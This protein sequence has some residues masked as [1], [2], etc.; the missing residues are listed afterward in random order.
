[1]KELRVRL[2]LRVS[3]NQQLEAD[4][5]LKIQRAID[6]E[7]V[8]SHWDEGWRLDGKEYFEGSNSGYHNGVLDRNILTEIRSDA[9]NNEFDILVVYKDDRVGRRMWEM[10]MFIMQL[11]SLGVDVYTVKD[12]CISPELDDIMGQMMLALRYGNAQKS[13]ADTGMRVRDTAEKLVKTGKFIGGKAGYGYKLILSGELSKHGRAL[14]KRQIVPEQA[15]AINY[16]FLLADIKEYGSTKIAKVLNQ[17]EYY[18]SLAPNDEWKSGTITSI[19]TNPLYAGYVSYNR[20]KKMNGKFR[21][22]S[23][24][25]WSIAEQPNE[26]IRIVDEERWER[27]QVKR[28]LRGAKY[29]KSLANKNVTVVNRNYGSLALID[30]AYCGYCGS[31]LTNG[32]KYNYWTIKGTGERRASKTPIYK[33]QNA[34]QGVVHDK[35]YQ[36]RADKVEAIIFWAISIYLD[37][38]L[39]QKEIFE[40]IE[41]NQNVEKKKIENEIRKM[42]E[43]LS[44]IRSGIEVMQTHIPEAILGQYT[45]SLEV[46]SDAIEKHKVKEQEQVQILKD[47]EKELDNI[48]VDKNELEEIKTKIPGW[49][50]IFLSA[51]SD[52]KR[53]LVNKLIERI[54]MKK[55]WIRIVFRISI[56]DFLPRKES[57]M[58]TEKSGHVQCR[59]SLGLAVPK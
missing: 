48:A 40:E 33:C 7:Y 30:V 21:R 22:L 18:H 19:L 38:I 31:K 14:H 54:E 55:D 52:T 17:D 3:S 4:G 57:G 26:E 58:V 24:D 47:K 10:G 8:E 9:A 49:K 2:L 59:K 53:V 42:K 43:E 11:K 41:K 56:N 13:S 37:S 35:V 34:W 29:K 23:N 16:I 45:L 15:E 12:G 6:V 28:S 39:N 1:M 25:E 51:D 27:V 36:F 32:S 5:D 44:K 46:L 50:E 20:R